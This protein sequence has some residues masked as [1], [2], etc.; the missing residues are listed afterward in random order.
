MQTE[1]NMTSTMSPMNR[2]KIK[3]YRQDEL[4]RPRPLRT[5]WTDR[6]REYPRSFRRVTLP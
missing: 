6:S 5:E 2:R 1:L 3:D 4:E